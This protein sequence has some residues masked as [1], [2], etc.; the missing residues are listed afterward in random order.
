[1][2]TTEFVGFSTVLPETVWRKLDSMV[3]GARRASAKLWA[4]TAA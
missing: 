1:M 3:E 4:K 2:T